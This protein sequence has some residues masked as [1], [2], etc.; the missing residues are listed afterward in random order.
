MKG[1]IKRFD[2]QVRVEVSNKVVEMVENGL[3]RSGVI[4]VPILRL[5]LF[6]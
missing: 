1:R 5:V 6:I 4:L 3:R 2:S